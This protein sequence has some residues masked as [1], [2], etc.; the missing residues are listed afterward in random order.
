MDQV[1]KVITIILLVLLL[2]S[3]QK[4]RFEDYNEKSFQDFVDKIL[5]AADNQI[6]PAAMIDLRASGDEE[7]PTSD[8][9]IN[10]HIEYFINYDYNSLG[11]DNFL[12][13]INYRYPKN[14]HIFLID[15]D[16]SISNLVSNILKEQGYKYIYYYTDGY[17]SLIERAKDQLPIATGNCDC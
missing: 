2:V 5:M 1:Q 6:R 4:Q 12:K 17:Q 15:G 10:G 14:T 7:D 9:Y 11:K 13:I 16:G 8:T 3:C